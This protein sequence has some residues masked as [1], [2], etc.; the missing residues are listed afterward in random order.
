MRLDI[1]KGG[2]EGG[3]ERR[4]GGREKDVGSGGTCTEGKSASTTRRPVVK[5]YTT[6]HTYIDAEQGG[7]RP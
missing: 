3:R 4:V 1:L 7:L 5:A 2:Y 6:Q